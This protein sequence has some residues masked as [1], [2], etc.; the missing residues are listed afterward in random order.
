MDDHCENEWH[1][2]EIISVYTGINF[3]LDRYESSCQYLRQICNNK[4]YRISL[5]FSLNILVS[6]ISEY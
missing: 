2:F 4:C 3:E 6:V 5:N 1:H